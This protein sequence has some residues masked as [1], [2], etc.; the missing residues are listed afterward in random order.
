MRKCENCTHYEKAD[1]SGIA[2]GVGEELKQSD[3]DM[4]T[5]HGRRCY[6]AIRRGCGIR[7][8][9]FEEKIVV[10]KPEV[11]EK[12]QSTKKKVSKKQSTK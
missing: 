2:K 6:V 10:E 7:R 3:Y 1:L 9:H 5:R 12:K 4:C 11:V 8:T